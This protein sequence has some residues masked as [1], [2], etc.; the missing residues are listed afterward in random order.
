MPSEHTIVLIALIAAGGLVASALVVRRDAWLPAARSHKRLVRGAVIGAVLIVVVALAIA[1]ADELEELLERVES[2]DPWWLAL[3]VGLE[4]VSFGGYV[5]LT[6]LIYRPVASKL[7]WTASVELT[8]A[9]VVATRVFSAGGA[10]GIAFTAWVLH[11]AGMGARATARRLAAFMAILYSVYMGALLI[12]GLVVVTGVLP[13]VPTALGWVAVGVG[14]VVVTL[15][16]LMLEIPADVERRVAA[17]ATESGRRGRIATRLAT[18]PQVAGNA[19]RLS[20]SIVR[21]NP[22]I[23]VW[24]FVWWAFDVAVLW[25]TFHAFGEAPAVGTIVLCYFLGSL[26]NLLPLPGGVGGTEGGMLGAFVASGVDA[27]LALLAI[28]SYQLISTYL[29]ALPGLVAYV[30]LRRRMKRWAP[31]EPVG[32]PAAAG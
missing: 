17:M 16:V 8:L 32:Q 7:D 4:V 3:A 19:A 20:I 2:G 5:V 9:G 31:E 24:P 29:P 25:A 21:G 23:L 13:D 26:G 15:V 10:G 12:G 11:R 18:V 22:S 1:H 28:V 30:D 27:G 14:G 6:G